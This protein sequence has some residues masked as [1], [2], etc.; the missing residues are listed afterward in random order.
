[1]TLAMVD[2]DDFKATNDEHGHLVGDE[3]LQLVSEALLRAVR[4]QDAASVWEARSSR[5]C[6]VE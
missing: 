5:S 6:S 3:A 4:E 2:I 1:M